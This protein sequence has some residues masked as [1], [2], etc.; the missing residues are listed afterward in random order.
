MFQWPLADFAALGR[1]PCYLAWTPSRW[2]SLLDQPGDAARTTPRR[3][4]AAAS[5]SRGAGRGVRP[6]AASAGWRRPSAGRF[7]CRP[8]AVAGVGWL[9]DHGRFRRR[10][11]CSCSWAAACSRWRAAMFPAPGSG[12]AC[13]VAAMSSTSGTSW[14]AATAWQRARP[15][16]SRSALRRWPGSSRGCAWRAGP[17]RRLRRFPALQFPAGAGLPRRRRQPRR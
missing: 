7:W 12:L 1:R 14:T 8:A 16:W 6:G 11:A 2:R 15:R 9:D 10:G 13:F 3:R 5:R 17:G 4:A